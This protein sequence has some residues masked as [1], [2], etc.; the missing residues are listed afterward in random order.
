MTQSVHTTRNGRV[1]EVV[2]DRPKANAIDNATS[3]ELGEIFCA[4]RD[5]PELR[6]AIITGGGERFFSAGWDLKAAADGAGFDEDYGPGGFAGLTELHDLNKPVIAALNGMAVGGGFELALCCDMI[7]AAEH[8]EVFLAEIHVGIIADAATYRLPRRIPYHIAME[9]LLT[10]RRMS[11]E[12]AHG[13]GIVNEVVPADKLMERTREIAEAIASGPPLVHAAIKDI[14]RQTA[15]MTIPE[16][17]AWTKSGACETYTT[18]LK[19][20]DAEEGPKSF[21]EGRDPVWKG[22]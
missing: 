13:W 20:E 6:C 1:L 21:A 16:C 15:N 7:V 19:S 8:V 14:V 17:Y 11:A 22:R 18:L 2:L 10:G 4:Y 5:D 12:E 3:R 9:M